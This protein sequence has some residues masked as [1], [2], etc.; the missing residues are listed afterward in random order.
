MSGPAGGC[1]CILCVACRTWRRPA[2]ASTRG[3]AALGAALL[4]ILA[5]P[6]SQPAFAVTTN[7]DGTST[8]TLN[9]LIAVSSLNAK[10]AAVGV[11]V[12]VAEVVP[13]CNAP[14]QIAGSNT[15][16]ATL[17]AKPQAGFADSI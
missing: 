13:G 9:A 16:P 15:P 6:A 10:L 17:L 5:G 12:R 8:V 3:I 7:P 4:L 11:H 1:W 14:V 2:S